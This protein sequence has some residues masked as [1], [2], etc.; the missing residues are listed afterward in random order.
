MHRAIHL[1]RRLTENE[2]FTVA[3]LVMWKDKLNINA[4]EHDVF[5]SL[6]IY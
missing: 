1:R 5:T 2:C 3:L 6:N 4:I